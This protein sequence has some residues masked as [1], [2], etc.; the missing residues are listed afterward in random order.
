MLGVVCI[1]YLSASALELESLGADKACWTYWRQ[2]ARSSNHS[3]N[4]NDQIVYQ[5]YHI[6]TKNNVLSQVGLLV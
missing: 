4:E 2:T 1:L 5:D 3:T 6:D